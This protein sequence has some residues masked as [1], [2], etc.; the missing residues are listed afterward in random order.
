MRKQLISVLMIV[1]VFAAILYYLQSGGV[2]VAPATPAPIGTETAVLGETDIGNCEV[3]FTNPT[4]K[5]IEVRSP[6]EGLI[7]LINGA[8]KTIDMAVFEFDLKSVKKALTKAYQRGVAIR[9]VYDNEYS[10]K[11]PDMGKLLSLGIKGVPDGREALMHNKFL[12]VDGKTVWTGS[13]NLTENA[14]H[15]NNEDAMRIESRE[16][17]G[18][19][20]DEFNKM[21]AGKFGPKKSDDNYPPLTICGNAKARVFFSP[22]GPKEA[23]LPVLVLAD[24]S[25]HIM[26]FSFTDDD[27]GNAAIAKSKAG[28]DVGAI[29]ENVGSG[30]EYSEFG[31]LKG[32]TGDCTDA[33]KATFHHKV[34]IVDADT[35]IFGSYNFTANAE[36]DNDENML[37]VE[38][39]A[40]AQKFEEEYQRRLAESESANLCILH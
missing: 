17:A 13:F 38:S 3:F 24:R 36:K 20:T 33:N 29:F 34:M 6:E 1:A 5:P 32:Q 2:V 7:E 23:I 26:A 31:R 4:G 16:L 14:A 40:I 12:V 19:Y 39:P 10:G 25:I 30:T 15:W 28:L 21:F 8:Q 37:I 11:D 27:I 9:V 35:V 22:D 18:Y